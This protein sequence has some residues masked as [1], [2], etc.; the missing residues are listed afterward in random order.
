[1]LRTSIEGATRRR[2][3]ELVW[4]GEFNEADRLTFPGVGVFFG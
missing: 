2:H 1:M 4:V 3:L